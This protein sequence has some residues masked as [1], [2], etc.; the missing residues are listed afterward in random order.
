MKLKSKSA[1]GVQ[2]SAQPSNGNAHRST[3][4]LV[5]R[6]LLLMLSIVIA[7]ALAEVG[8]MLFFRSHFVSF[9]DERTLLYR[10]DRT[11]GW[12]PIANSK[13]Q[14]LASRVITVQ[15]NSEGFRAP[16]RVP[17]DKP[18]L[19]F[20]GDSFVW[21]YDVNAPERF[22]DKL[23]ER[24]PEWNVY[25][26]G[27]SGYGTDQEYL[28][29]QQRFDAYRPRVVFLLYCTE[30]DED[31]NSSNLIH[32]DYYKPYYT[33]TQGRLEL[34]G[35]P[36]PRSQ[37]AFLAEHP[38]LAR[39]YVAQLLVRSYFAIT[40]PKP[41]HNP[42]PTGSI[43]RD[44]QKFVADRGAVLVVGITSS[45][46]ALEE[47]LRLL[48]IPFLDLSTSLRYPGFGSHWT[49]EGNTFVCEKIDA[50]LMAGKLMERDSPPQAP[51]PQTQ[52]TPSN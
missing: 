11:L 14:F 13:D 8:L 35:V 46:P 24:H 2:A 12:F 40:A 48:K 36:V 3:N 37:R 27:V 41:V 19:V 43:I 1:P 38:I 49:P 47:F 18:G 45:N 22:T 9:E 25:N 5:L 17:N 52:A 21:G 32:G 34:H 31:D 4:P 50:F 44:L 7:V 15:N 20:L 39:S 23:Q 16:E 6:L 10:Y 28:L 30:T 42:D 26:F 33:M 51:R 29:L